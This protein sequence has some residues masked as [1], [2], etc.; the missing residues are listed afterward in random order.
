[1]N[2]PFFR[3]LLLSFYS[4][5]A[6]QITVIIFSIIIIFILSSVLFLS[7][8]M[9][10]S[11][12]EALKYQP[13]F[14]VQKMAGD[15]RVN[16]SERVTDELIEIPSI[17]KV[18]PR[19]YGR[20]FL[21]PLGKSFLVVGVD[22][23]DVQSHRGLEK[24]IDN[25]DLNKFFKRRDNMLVGEGVDRFMREHHYDNNMT[26]FTPKGKAITLHKFAT[27]P[28]NSE[29]VSSDM[30][31]V[32]IDLAKKILGIKRREVSDFA[33]NV[34]NILEWE[35]VTIKVS[36]LDYDLRVINKKESYKAYAEFFDFKGGFFL[37]I[38]LI[39]LISFS[40]ILYQRYSQLYS[41]ERRNIGV[42]RALGWS[43]K[44]TL[45]LKFFEALLVVFISYTIGVS[46]AYI[47]VYIFHAPILK[48]IFL[49]SSN[50]MVEPTFVPVI[51]IFLLSS[52][53][54]LYA[55]PFI[56]SVIIPVWRI[57]TTNPK[58]AMR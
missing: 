49:G 52:I 43:I 9:H 24:I 15:R 46:L 3:F 7:T 12:T 13:D 21:K 41:T 30:V 5:K 39:V 33:F 31:I 22:F 58:E 38:F 27:L 36:A 2:S 20:Y 32:P 51:D 47:F 11:I 53:F 35:I 14:I 37:S 28:K 8:S 26:F 29:L 57:S 25:M 40:L 44:D 17:A 1:M 23:F 48:N 4:E 10:Y 45:K 19:V 54:L 42:L 34:P 55:I 16:I 56:A 50:I 6:K 18:T